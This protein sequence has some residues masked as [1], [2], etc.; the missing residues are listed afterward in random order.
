MDCSQNQ[1]LGVRHQAYT[2]KVFW[3]PQGRIG[4]SEDNSTVGGATLPL[5]GAFLGRPRYFSVL[6]ASTTVARVRYEYRG[7]L[8]Y[9]VPLFRP[10]YFRGTTTV[11][12]IFFFFFYGC[13]SSQTKAMG[14]LAHRGNL[15]TALPFWG[16][17]TGNL[18]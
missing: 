9:G 8:R 11:P 1:F 15:R 3:P 7:V 12:N 6:Y 2:P 10:N 13:F 4:P 14:L 5:P 17:I 18:S 16:K